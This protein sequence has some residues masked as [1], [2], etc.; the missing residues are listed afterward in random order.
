MSGTSHATRGITDKA[1]ISGVP[2]I[3]S[4]FEAARGRVR[5][6]AGGSAAPAI[7]AEGDAR[8]VEETAREGLY[9]LLLIV[10]TCLSGMYM[11]MYQMSCFCTSTMIYPLAAR[12]FSLYRLGGTQG[13]R[14]HHGASLGPG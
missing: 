14:V 1:G 4:D 5:R 2:V 11:H 7:A 6:R 12:L 10:C 8:L 9:A 13:T 3:G